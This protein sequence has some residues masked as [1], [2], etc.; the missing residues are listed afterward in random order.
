L[1]KMAGYPSGFPAFRFFGTLADVAR[2]G[3]RWSWI[4]TF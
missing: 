1:R 2:N 3:A 4:S